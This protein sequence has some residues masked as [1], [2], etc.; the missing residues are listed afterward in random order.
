[1]DVE[2]WMSPDPRTVAPNDPG[3]E[4]RKVMAYY[5]IHHLPVADDGELVG[6]ISDRDLLE[7]PDLEVATAADL[8][9]P[10]P[11]LSYP[12]E[13]ITEAARQMLAMRVNAL[14]VVDRR[15][16]LVGLLTSTDCL[17][18]LMESA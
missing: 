11:Y 16:E 15:G 12:E 13:P 5:G 1:M 17:L 4:V 18:A 10:A 3:T 14:P 2:R 7:C 9:T 6:I 8:M